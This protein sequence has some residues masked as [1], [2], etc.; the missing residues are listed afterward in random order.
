MRVFIA[1]EIP[2]KVKKELA[3]VLVK[4]KRLPFSIKWVELD[5]LHFTLS[6][7]GNIEENKLNNLYQ[8]AGKGLVGVSSFTIN[9]SKVICLPNFKRPRVIALGLGGKVG[10]LEKLQKQIER[11]LLDAG[12]K[13]KT[14]TKFSPHLTLGRVRK[15]VKRF[16]RIKLGRKLLNFSLDF[17]QEFKVDSVV[18]FKSALSSKGP[19]YTKLKEFRLSTQP[20]SS[21]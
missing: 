20:L 13:P 17:E 9:L 19:V 14:R 3:E 2:N 21:V 11:S 8:V 1:I 12:F 18:I 4:L 5:N 16:E 10:I 7:L 15:K 6:F